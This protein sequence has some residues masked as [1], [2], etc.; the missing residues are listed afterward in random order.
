MNETPEEKRNRLLTKIK[1]MQSAYG[2]LH[3]EGIIS[4][5]QGQVHCG[6]QKM[7]EL[8]AKGE[9]ITASWISGGGLHLTAIKDG[10]TFVYLP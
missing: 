4:V 8:F 1:D 2:E 10:M 7:F 5:E 9:P 3:D 6:D